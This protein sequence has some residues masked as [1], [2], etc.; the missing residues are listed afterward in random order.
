M[1][2]RPLVLAPVTAI[3]LAACGS[4]G[5]TD[6]ALSNPTSPTS[7]TNPT[8]PTSSNQVTLGNDFFSPSSI[9]VPVNSTVTWVWGS[10]VVTHNVTFTD[11]SG[12]GDKNA[13]DTFAKTFT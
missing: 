12:S 4:G 2:F 1:R 6:A 11:G 9:S 8:T 13:G 7:P 5:T 3:I 10:D